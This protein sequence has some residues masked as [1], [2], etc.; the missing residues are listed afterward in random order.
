MKQLRRADRTS[1][2]VSDRSSSDEGFE[3]GKLKVTQ[4][5]H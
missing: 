5:Q 2:F 1:G 4:Q 3:E